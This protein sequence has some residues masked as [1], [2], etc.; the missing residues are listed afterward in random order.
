VWISSRSVAVS[1]ELR[2]DLT[3]PVRRAV[4]DEDDVPHCLEEVR[5]DEGQRA[6][7]ILDPQHSGDAPSGARLL[8]RPVH[9]EG[10]VGLEVGED[11]RRLHRHAGGPPTLDAVRMSRRRRPCGSL[12]R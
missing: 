3:G 7:L 10:M 12:R 2:R 9:I 4:V 6:R 11:R 1:G 8:P 5:Q